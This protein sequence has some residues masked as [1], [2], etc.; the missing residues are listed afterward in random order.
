MLCEEC[1]KYEAT[2]HIQTIA[3]DGSTATRSLCQRCVNKMRMMPGVHA[4][5]I[6]EFLGALFERIHQSKLEKDSDRFEAT[7]PMCG[8]SYA[9]Y[10]KD[11]RLGCAEC[12]KAF[13]EPIEEALVKRNDS[14]IY[15]GRAPGGE[16]QLNGDIYQIKKLREEMQRAVNEEKFE[17]AA[18]IRD[19]IRALED[20]IGARKEA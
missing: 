14:A 3:P 12:Y 2:V 19:E 13:R 7:C 5:D 1:G 20:K 6:G 18:A 16:Q 15:V 11:Q 17:T 8:L 10:K 4:L 9:D